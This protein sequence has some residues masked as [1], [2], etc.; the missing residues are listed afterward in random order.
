MRER[1]KQEEDDLEK[2]EQG[3]IWPSPQRSPSDFTVL[4]DFGTFVIQQTFA[5]EEGMGLSL[6][7]LS[8]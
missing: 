4:L 1:E 7:D 8:D 5:A 2:R 3:G 6:V